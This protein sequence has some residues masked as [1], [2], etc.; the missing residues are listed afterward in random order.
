[1]RKEQ[2]ILLAGV[3]IYLIFAFG[4][5]GPV[6]ITAFHLLLG[7]TVIFLP[8][9]SL[10]IGLKNSTRDSSFLVFPVLNFFW[11]LFILYRGL[12]D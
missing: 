2:F 12:N 7:L 4:M 10:V 1:M 9:A 5:K 8:L 3:L 11:I 6:F